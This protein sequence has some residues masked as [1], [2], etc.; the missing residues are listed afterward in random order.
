MKRGWRKN[1]EC[2]QTAGILHNTFQIS[3]EELWQTAPRGR[4]RTQPK[5][6]TR[7]SNTLRLQLKQTSTELRAQDFSGV[8]VKI[9]LF[10]NWRLR[11]LR[12]QGGK[13]QQTVGKH[14]GTCCQIRLWSGLM[15]RSTFPAGSLIRICS[16]MAEACRLNFV[17]GG[18][19]H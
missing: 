14:S 8:G 2:R 1:K 13:K 7:N 19:L 10:G 4:Q 9:L 16:G 3:V 17:F 11:C 5:T 12:E 6:D 18:F 15:I